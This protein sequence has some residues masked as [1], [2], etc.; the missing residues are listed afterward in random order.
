VE[1]EGGLVMAGRMDEDGQVRAALA[2]VM[3]EAPAV[4]SNPQL[5]RN[6]LGDL[7]PGAPREA[8]ILV[9][10]ADAGIPE[11]LRAKAAQLGGEPAVVQVAQALEDRAGLSAA[12]SRWAVT[13]LGVALGLL[14]AGQHIRQPA[15]LVTIPPELAAPPISLVVSSEPG[16]ARTGLTA[17]R[18]QTRP[19]A[20]RGGLA[21]ERAGRPPR[22]GAGAT[23]KG[24]D[25][26]ERQHGAANDRLA[27]VAGL[28]ALVAALL[29]ALWAW[30][31]PFEFGLAYTWQLPA[32]GLILAAAGVMT[33]IRS[34]A[35]PAAVGA[36]FGVATLLAGVNAVYAAFFDASGA[37][38]YLGGFA[39]DLFGP[40]GPGNVRLGPAQGATILGT[41]ALLVAAAASGA[42]LVRE[43]GLSWRGQGA[44]AGVWCLAGLGYVVIRVPLWIHVAPYPPLAGQTVYPPPAQETVFGSA[45]PAQSVAVL[46][47]L[48]ATFAP[49]AV[50]GL[51]RTG[52]RGATAGV[53]AGWLAVTG[54]TLCWQT[55]LAMSLAREDTYIHPSGW[56]KAEWAVWSVVVVL[57]IAAWLRGRSARPA[58]A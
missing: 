25:T 57:A 14:P 18:T 20:E 39:V 42:W 6:M 2:E 50:G 47:L 54:V 11:L 26:G 24:A 48:L 29:V 41:V 49:L 45:N 51:L 1:P 21:G 28:A 10:A 44:L 7:L 4:L 36:L 58:S 15:E 34:R 23:R 32:F 35:R 8:V 12:A 40:D 19:M 16:T 55:L 37:G 46:V 53:A 5:L 27:L 33:L 43:A 30:A 9:A 17:D 38:S 3:A 56:W 52:T 13:E 22:A 31:A